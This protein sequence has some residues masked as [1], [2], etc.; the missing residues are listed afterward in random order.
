MALS[1]LQKGLVG[2]GIA[3]VAVIAVGYGGM[4]YLENAV[5]DA[6]RT[7]AAQTP[8]DAHVE[9]GDIS[10]TLMDNHL[11]LKNVRMTYVTPAK[12]TVAATVETLDIRNPGTTL[13]SLMRD[14]KSEIKEA[15]LPVADEIALHNLS[16]GPEPNITVRLRTFKG[17]AI[18]TAAVKTLMSTAGDDDPKVALAIIYGLSYKEDSA[19]G[20]KI[21]SKALPFSLSTDSAVQKSY[22]KGH[23]DSSVTNGIVFTLRGQ[24]V[25][26]L[27][28]IRLENMNLPPRDIMEKIYFIAPTDI[29][30]DEA[31]GI[32]QNLFAGPKPLIGLLSL[33]DLKTNS[34]LLDISLDKLN[35]TNPSTSP[36]ALE[37]SLEHLKMPVALVPEL[38]LLSVMGVPEIDASASYAMSLPNKDN[39]FNSTASLS[40]AK[41]GTADFAVK[42][43]VPYKAFFEI[44]NNN[45]VTDS[46]IENFVE[47]NI[48][49]SHIEAGYA[50]EGLLPRLG[51]LGQKF[52]GLTPEQ[53]VDMAK[54]YVKESLGA[55][56]GTENTAK[57][58]EYIDKPGA[59]RLIFNTEKPIPVEAFDTLSDTD[60]SIK[61]DVNTGPKTAQ[62]LMAD[63]EKK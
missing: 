56:E 3:V 8:Q 5:V 33:K 24:D 7:W 4:R 36:Y 52:M 46:D 17:V 57:L 25:L 12:Q 2:L 37:V 60:P 16:F 11:V 39:Q 34:A 21:T 32:F 55:A 59:I 40:V 48:K 14:P 6:I 15:E 9:L 51:I 53:C 45:S 28:E 10:Y 50:D 49:F 1:K 42:G 58:M 43:E 62:E 23:L 22:A 47:K 54:K 41:L 61:L 30:D 19:S 26:T 35:I 18:E 44:I 27:G 38:Q 31:F 13:L 29:N 20:V 63:L